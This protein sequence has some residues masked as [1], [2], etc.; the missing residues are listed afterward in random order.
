[1]SVGADGAGDGVAVDGFVVVVVL[2]VPAV[3]VATGLPDPPGVG[4][5]VLAIGVR[6]L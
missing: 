2:G 4:C 3:D 1:L 6:V 5:G